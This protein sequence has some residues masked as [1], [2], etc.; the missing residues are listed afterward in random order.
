M[1]GKEFLLLQNWWESKPFVELSSADK[2]HFVDPETIPTMIVHQQ[3]LL[4]QSA[5]LLRMF[6]K[7]KCRAILFLL[8][9]YYSI[10]LQL[11]IGNK[12]MK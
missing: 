12:G 1:G 10:Y 3:Q 8:L 5:M 7:K 4:I 2:I 6:L 9:H 11:I